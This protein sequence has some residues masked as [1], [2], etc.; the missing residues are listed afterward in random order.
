MKKIVSLIYVIAVLLFCSTFTSCSEDKEDGIEMTDQAKAKELLNGNIV[1]STKATMSG[2]DKTL[3]PSGCP[4]KFNFVWNDDN[5]MTISL[6]DFTVGSM[7]FAVSFKCRTKIMSVS[8]FDEQIGYYKNQGWIKFK[9]ENGNVSS[10][11]D[12]PKDCQT[13]SGATVDGYLNIKSNQVEF[14]INYNMMNVRTETFRQNI[15]K[16][17]INNF[18]AEFAQYEQDLAN[19]KKEHGV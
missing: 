19:Y 18:E 1:L 7:P 15:D 14:I 5:T 10:N 9:G 13:G 3:L 2:V 17:R 6:T 8:E 16:S 4:T 12:D 11:G